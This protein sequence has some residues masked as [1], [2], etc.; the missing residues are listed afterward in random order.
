[1]ISGSGEL[2]TSEGEVLGFAEEM[3]G[4]RGDSGMDLAVE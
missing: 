4:L 1:M 3:D 2:G